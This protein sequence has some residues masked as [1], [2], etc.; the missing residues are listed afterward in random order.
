MNKV[1]LNTLFISII[2]LIFTMFSIQIFSSASRIGSPMA[3]AVSGSLTPSVIR[4][5]VLVK[6]GD[7]IGKKEDSLKL[8]Q[9]QMVNKGEVIGISSKENLLASRD[10]ILYSN[11]KEPLFFTVEEAVNFLING[12]FPYEKNFLAL[13]SSEDYKIVMENLPWDVNEGQ[14]LT[15]KNVY[16]D[17]VFKVNVENRIS[18]QGREFLVLCGDHYTQEVLSQ[19]WQIYYIEQKP[20]EGIITP[21]D[22]LKKENEKYF[23]KVLFRGKIEIREVDLLAKRGSEA[24]VSGIPTNSFILPWKVYIK[25][26]DMKWPIL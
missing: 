11:M 12:G 7:L 4:V 14:T 5:G 24:L 3:I 19:P 1:I 20:I 6:D 26:G 22:Y 15:L 13:L 21:V 25:W 18:Y 23:V 17:R 16:D 2:F 10:G 8:T 9:G